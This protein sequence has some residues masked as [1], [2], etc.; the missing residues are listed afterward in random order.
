LVFHYCSFNKCGRNS[1]LTV[2]DNFSKCQTVSSESLWRT[3][4]HGQH[5]QA[6]KSCI[7]SHYG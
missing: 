5:E 1:F 4:V 2:Q 7:C 3:T 6:L